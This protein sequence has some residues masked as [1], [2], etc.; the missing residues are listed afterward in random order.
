MQEPVR[1]AWMAPLP[2]SDP[3]RLARI[4]QKVS[5]RL[6]AHPL[7]S[8]IWS[9]RIDMFEVPDFL[10]A[11]ECAELV[12]MIDADVK[13]STSLSDGSDNQVR[14]SATC[15]L[16][17]DHPLVARVAAR[18]AGLLGL[19][20]S[21]A[22]TLQGQ[23][24]LQ[25]QHFRVHNDYFASGQPYSDAVASEGGQRSWTAMA[26]LNQP[27]QGGATEFPLVPLSIAPRTGLLLVWNNVD[28]AG[29][30]NPWSHHAGMPVEAGT[31]YVLTKWFRERE[32]HDARASDGYRA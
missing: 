27:E 28:A 29:Q 32:W 24:Y 12:A 7:A 16:A 10:T 9:A 22:E 8:R 18:I 20:L 15:K 25:G 23:R 6:D 21:H 5:A 17:A 30:S 31:K 3:A 4:G 19:R 11:A 14:T 2:G 26:Y 1:E 13:P